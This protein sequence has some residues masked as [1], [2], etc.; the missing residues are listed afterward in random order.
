[1]AR[2]RIFKA[3]LERCIHAGMGPTE[4]AKA[5]GCAKSTISERYRSLLKEKLHK[6]TLKEGES[7][8]GPC[9]REIDLEFSNQLFEKGQRIRKKHQNFEFTSVTDSLVK[10]NGVEF[11]PHPEIGLK[12][13]TERKP[14]EYKF[15]YLRIAEL[16]ASGEWPEIDTYR[17]LILNDLWFVLFFVVKPFVDA[18]GRARANHPFTVRACREIEEGPRDYTL[19]IWARFHFKSSGITIGE[20]IQYELKNPN[21]ATAIFSHTSPAAKD[22]LFSIKSIFENE[23]IL[24]ACFPDVAWSEPKK[25]APLWSLNEGIILKRDTNRKEASVSAHGLVEGMPTGLHFER[26][27]YDDVTTLDVASNPTLRKTSKLWWAHT[28]E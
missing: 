22:F 6:E 27:I 28:I 13:D 12:S 19:D 9:F 15:N 20:T 4:A 26:R 16:I 23:K 2:K 7:K 3:D 11:S 1:M 21:H 8:N 17:A 18:A 24:P 14:I 5:L 25:E 10:I